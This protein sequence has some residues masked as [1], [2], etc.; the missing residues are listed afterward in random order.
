ML[1]FRSFIQVSKKRDLIKLI[2]IWEKHRTKKIM[3]GKNV[4]L[5]WNLSI[6]KVNS[7]SLWIWNLVFKRAGLQNG[8]KFKKFKII[9]FSIKTKIMQLQASFWSFNKYKCTYFRNITP[10]ISVFIS[11][12]MMQ[13][14]R[15]I[16]NKELQW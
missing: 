5:N 8:A 10:K 11:L 9:L 12:I 13:E 14:W 3:N 2:K 4:Y 15:I 7:S 6:S 1:Y 16:P